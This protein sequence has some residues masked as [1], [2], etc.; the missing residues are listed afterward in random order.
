MKLNYKILWIDDQIEDIINLGIKDDIQEHL[1]NLEF[2]VTI[3]CYETRDIAEEKLKKNKYDLI[4]SDYNIGQDENMGDALV[5]WIRRNEIFTEVLF[6][7]VQRNFE[8]TLSG[9]D[10]ISYFGLYEDEAYKEFKEKVFWL[11]KQTVLKFEELTPMRGLVM[12]ETSILDSKVENIL[13]DYFTVDNSE[14]D[15]LRKEILEKIENSLLGNF[16]K[17]E[18]FNRGLLTLKLSGKS[19]SDIVKSR[20]YDASKKARTVENLIQLHGMAENENFIDFFAK[21]EKDVIET[22][23]KLAHARSEIIDEIEWLIINDGDAEKYDAE[24]CK[25]IRKC[26][27]KYSD[28]LDELHTVVS[29]KVQEIVNENERNPA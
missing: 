26:L 9:T 25:E 15:K 17:N 20:T 3:D 8:Q 6:Y 19:S 11:I 28:C 2:G 4:L 18:G 29:D 24:A 5:E 27:K 10:R 1:E 23:N 16:S 12:A 14:R 7:S 13:S 22:R 21:Y